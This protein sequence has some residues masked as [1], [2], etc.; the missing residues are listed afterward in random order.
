MIYINYMK[1]FY[2]IM[3]GIYEAS[4]RLYKYYKINLRTFNEI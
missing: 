1:L 4:T 3:Y 2:E